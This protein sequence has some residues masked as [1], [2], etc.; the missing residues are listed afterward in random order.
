MQPQGERK[1]PFASLFVGN[2]QKNEGTSIKKIK[3]GDGPVQLLKEDIE[4]AV[5][6]WEHNLLPNPPLTLWGNSSLAKIT[7]K[8]GNPICVDK[9]TANVERVL[10]ARAL[11]E[12]DVANDVA[13]IHRSNTCKVLEG[14]KA[15]KSM[16]TQKQSM[17][18]TSTKPIQGFVNAKMIPE[19]GKGSTG[20]QDT[21]AGAEKN[22]ESQN[23]WVTKKGIAVKERQQVNKDTS[24]AETLENLFKVLKDIQETEIQS[25]LPESN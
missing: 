18:Q 19:F 11:V 20:S 24:V 16:E 2:K 17:G 9:Y 22:K 6:R 4:N 8:I 23:E 13:K 10:Y 5:D 15:K 12:I 7:S 3:V 25:L 21:S 1:K 14:I